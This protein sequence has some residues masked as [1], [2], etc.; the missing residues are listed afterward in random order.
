MLSEMKRTL[1]VRAALAAA[2]FLIAVP[3]MADTQFRLRQMRRDDVPLGKGQCDIRLQ[4]DDEVEVAVRGDVVQI[5]TIAGRD[6]YDDGNSECNAPLPNRDV[7]DF[8]FEV[9]DSRNDIRLLAEPSRR[10]GYAAIVR[11]RDSKG[12]QGRYHFRLT[13]RMTGSDYRPDRGG[14]DDPRGGSDGPRGG[15]GFQWNN[16]IS[17]R[18]DGRGM[19]NYGGPG[20]DRRLSGVN[21]DIDRNGRILVTFRTD[22]GVLV[23]Q[24]FVSGREG[25]RLRADVQSEDRRLRGPMF[26]MVDNRE[27]VD[28]IN[29]EAT[30]G[31]E[32]LRLNWDRR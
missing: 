19:A 1:P 22:R 18:G 29:L 25:N 21:V 5:R 30:D 11:I 9:R 32:R 20:G 28:S 26:V 24:G 31:R 4:V 2:A 10:N 17:F 15:R 27:R 14:Y 7:E 23:F 16:T 8:G 6:A 13:W 12:G 3:A